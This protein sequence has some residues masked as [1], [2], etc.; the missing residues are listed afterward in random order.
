MVPVK[1]MITSCHRSKTVSGVNHDNFRCL[2]FLSR[3]KKPGKFLRIDSH[4]HTEVIKLAQFCL[5]H[6]VSG[7]YEMHGVNFTVLLLSP[8]CHKGNKRVLLMAGFSSCGRD[9]LFSIMELS[10]LDVTFSCPGSMKRQHGKIL[11]V[12]IQAGT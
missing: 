7:I 8:V 12:H 1:V 11:I 4:S 2:E 3:C 10:G 5:R 9:H 6:K